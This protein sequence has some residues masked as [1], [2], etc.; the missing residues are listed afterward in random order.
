MRLNEIIPWGRAFE[1][2]A[3]MF[4]LTDVDL[5]GDILGC[6]DGRPASPQKWT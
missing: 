5:A 3:R 1:E 4:A 6:G 2:Y